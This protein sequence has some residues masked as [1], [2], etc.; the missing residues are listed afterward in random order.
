MKQPNIKQLRTFLKGKGL[1]ENY[2]RYIRNFTK[3]F[4]PLNG[5]PTYHYIGCAFDWLNTREG[6]KYW[7]EIND[8]WEKL[9]NQ[10]ETI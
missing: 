8:C 1:W 6:L 7:C 5:V 9:I 4:Y 2:C 10:H 3:S